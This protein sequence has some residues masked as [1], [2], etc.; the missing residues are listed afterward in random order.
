MVV[1]PL[2]QRHQS[3]KSEIPNGKSRF[4]TPSLVSGRRRGGGREQSF[5]LDANGAHAAHLLNPSMDKTVEPVSQEMHILQE[6]RALALGLVSSI[7]HLSPLINNHL[8]QE[9]HISKAIPSRPAL[10]SSTAPRSGGNSVINAEPQAALSLPA[11][12]SVPSLIKKQRISR[13][14]LSGF[15]FHLPFLSLQWGRSRDRKSV[16]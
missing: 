14:S 3:L 8:P 10:P 9:W 5:D 2:K 7:C 1:K 12:V 16:V 6:P 4:L 11:P 13:P 15:P